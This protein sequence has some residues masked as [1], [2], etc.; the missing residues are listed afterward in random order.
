M[1]H[2]YCQDQQSPPLDIEIPLSF[3][4]E[5]FCFKSSSGVFSKRQADQGSLVLLR[6]LVGQELSGELLDVGCGYGLLGI[7]IKRCFPALQVAMIDINE[8]AVELAAY[9]V[10]SH[11][12]ECR[13]WGSDGYQAVT[14]CYDHIITNPPIRAGKAVVY[15]ILGEAY[16]H[17]NSGGDCYAVIR[18]KQGALSAL[19][20]MATVYRQVAVI[21]R[22]RGYYVLRGQK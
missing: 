3:A 6:C 8:R 4:G 2:Y 21:K 11:R 12:V 20:Y 7:V 5:S 1:S 18:K 22:E 16:D 9:N 13:V 14:A 15:R 10:E 19:K 17:L